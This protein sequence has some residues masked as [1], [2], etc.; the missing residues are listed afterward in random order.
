[1]SLPVLSYNPISS[2]Y[3]VQDYQKDT[4]AVQ[5]D[6]GDARYRKNYDNNPLSVNVEWI[7]QDDDVTAFHYFYNTT[8]AKGASPF[9]ISLI[10]DNEGFESVKAYFEPNS[11]KLQLL[12][13]TVQS[14]SA[15]LLV[16]PNEY[17]IEAGLDLVGGYNEFGAGWQT[18]FPPVED[19]FNTLVNVD[20]PATF[21]PP[22]AWLREGDL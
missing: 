9:S 1:M 12:S 20:I 18:A 11:I 19:D 7:L 14:I 13:D 17:D 21:P 10:L 15:T 4:L 22:D 6:G 8:I 5:F 2:S 16:E 3:G